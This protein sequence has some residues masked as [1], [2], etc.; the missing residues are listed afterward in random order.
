[1][2]Y[3]ALVVVVVFLVLYRGAIFR[4]RG[5]GIVARRGM[6]IGADV[7]ALADKPRVRVRS[8]MIEGP[9]RVRVVLTPEPG[10]PEG[11][12][13][14]VGP[15][16]GPGTSPDL[17]LVVALNE[18]EFGFE[19]LHEWKRSGTSIAMVIPPDSRLVRLRSIDD[20]QPLTL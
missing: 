17:D 6:S 2:A 14:G 1:M 7:G 9:D 8:V 5:R 18:D 10:G 4:H 13:P 15:G 3:V 19:L 12:A 11:G 16:V 20:L